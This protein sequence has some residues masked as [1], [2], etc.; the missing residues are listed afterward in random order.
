MDER[1]RFG[2]HLDAVLDKFEKR[3]TALENKSDTILDTILYSFTLILSIS[4]LVMSVIALL[5]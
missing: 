2:K 3:L 1:R 4:A 5:K